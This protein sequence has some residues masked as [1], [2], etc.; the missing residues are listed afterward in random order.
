MDID[1]LVKI[2]RK[3]ARSLDYVAHND[4]TNAAIEADIARRGND[5]AAEAAA[6]QRMYATAGARAA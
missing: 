5:R 1:E 4:F 3:A 2:E 6:V